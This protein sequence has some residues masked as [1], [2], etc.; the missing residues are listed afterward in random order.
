MS[1]PLDLSKNAEID[2][3]IA[4]E[5][6]Q[7]KAIEAQGAAEKILRHLHYHIEVNHLI[8]S[9][10]LAALF[11]TANLC[12]RLEKQVRDLEVLNASL[13]E[14]LTDCRY[15]YSEIEAAC[16][17]EMAQAVEAKVLSRRKAIDAAMEERG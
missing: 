13:R 8:N 6:E 14:S 17:G 4:R 3:A 16:G 2:A 11:S 9:S 12:R 1:D 15:H 7:A 5:S 10:T